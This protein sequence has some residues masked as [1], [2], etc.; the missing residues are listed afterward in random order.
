[1]NSSRT[2]S[3]D[4][5]LVWG[6]GIVL[7]AY[8]TTAALGWPQKGTAMIAASAEHEATVEA[9]SPEHEAQTSLPPYWMILPFA[10]LL[11]VIAV[12]P[13]TPKVEHWWR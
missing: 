9:V 11:G 5:R 7:A 2:A 13:L 12:F 10:I 4:N 1:M 6:I 8:L 3:S